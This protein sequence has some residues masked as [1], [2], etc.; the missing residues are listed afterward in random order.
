MGIL[1]R[2]SR[3]YYW[4]AGRGDETAAGGPRSMGRYSGASDP[5]VPGVRADLMSRRWGQETD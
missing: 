5:A 1:R 4:V 2:L 3:E